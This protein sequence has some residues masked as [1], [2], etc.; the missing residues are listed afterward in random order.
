MTYFFAGLAIMWT[1]LAIYWTAV[2]VTYVAARTDEARPEAR[3][4]KAARKTHPAHFSWSRD[5]LHGS[6]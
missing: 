2:V 1:F 5:N 4:R 6:N 3:Y